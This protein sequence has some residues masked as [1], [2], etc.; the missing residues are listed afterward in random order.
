[1]PEALGKGADG[2]GKH[3]EQQQVLLKEKS[4]K[5][6]DAFNPAC[7]GVEGVSRHGEREDPACSACWVVV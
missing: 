6:Q 4:V 5:E 2:Y 1:M 7:D 3:N